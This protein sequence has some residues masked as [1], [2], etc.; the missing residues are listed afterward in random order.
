MI[1]LFIASHLHRSAR[2]LGERIADKFN[3]A[4]ISADAYQDRG[5]QR[6]VSLV[7][8]IPAG[9]G[10]APSLLRV[11]PGS[12]LLPDLLG[13]EVDGFGK[14]AD[15]VAESP[16]PLRDGIALTIRA[17][18]EADPENLPNPCFALDDR[19]PLPVD[20][21]ENETAEEVAA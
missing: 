21:E 19:A 18:I 17:D 8:K 13:V 9:A 12:C 3:G 20:G 10:V 14:V 7:V 6:W 5:S 11:E 16:H 15:L 4:L 2:S 1:P